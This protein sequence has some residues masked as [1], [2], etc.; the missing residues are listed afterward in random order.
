MKKLSLLFALAL[1]F[2][3]SGAQKEE[4]LLKH[5][6]FF[7]WH[8]TVT[9]E[10]IE[11]LVGIFAALP[12]KIEVIQDLEYG[13]DVSVEGLQKGFTHCFILTFASEKERDIY[14]P[15]PDHQALGEALGPYLDDVMVIDFVVNK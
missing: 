4:G 5:V 13:S 15:H 11:E 14:L 7:K 9:N 6:V 10:K 8:D 3:C 12:S 1:L 2:S